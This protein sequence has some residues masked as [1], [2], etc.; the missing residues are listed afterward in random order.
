MKYIKISYSLLFDDAPIWGNPPAFVFR[1]VLGLSLHKLTCILR[2]QEGCS[3][4]MVK[5][6]CVYSVFF[7][8]N[9][10]KNISAL[11][12]R[13]KAA[14]PFVL[15]VNK[16][17]SKSATIEIVFIGTAINYI[18]YINIA[19]ENAGKLGIGRNRVQF[20]IDYISIDNEPFD[21]NLVEEKTKHWPSEV[22]ETNKITSIVLETPCRIKKQGHY[23]AK[24]TIEDLLRSIY[25]R[26]QVLS[27]LFSEREFLPIMD[28][29]ANI[30]STGENQRWIESNYY[31][32]RQ[33]SVLKLGGVVGEINI[34]D[35]S[36]SKTTIDYIRA[37][38]LFH[39]GKNIS[40]GYGKIK[41]VE[42]EC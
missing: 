25:L 40:F 31:S 19:L 10:D 5:R 23:L 11:E 18:P 14:H 33:R 39:V 9:V 42:G 34:G 27:E 15:E 7:E 17:D 36:L 3:D 8:T 29:E 30:T 4:C 41:V 21:L 6:N 13:N 24:I 35:C 28:F 38:E 1:S 16:I 26:M 20:R 12:G 2:G 37:M 22:S 32:G